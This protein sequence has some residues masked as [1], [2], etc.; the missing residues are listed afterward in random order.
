VFDVTFEQR[1]YFASWN[2]SQQFQNISALF[3][4]LFKNNFVLFISISEEHLLALPIKNNFQSKTHFHMKKNLLFFLLVACVTI[5][6]AQNVEKN[7]RGNSN[8]NYL[9]TSLEY[10]VG[11]TKYDNQSSNSVHNSIVANTDGTIAITYTF[12]P[13]STMPINPSHPNRGSGYNYYDGINW[14]A[15]NCTSRV[16]NVR[17]GFSNIVNTSSGA[18]LLIAHENVPVSTYSRIAVSRRAVKGTGTWSLSYPWGSTSFDTW[19]KAT[20]SGDNVYVVFQGSGAP[21]TTTSPPNIV[22]GQ[23]GPLYFSR[24][25]DGGITWDPKMII[26]LIDSSNY[27]GFE[28]DAYSIDARDSIVAISYGDSKIDVGLL[29]STDY[30][31]TWTKTI[32]QQHPIPFYTHDSITDLNH[33]GITDTVFT[34]GGDSHVLIDLNGICHV[35]FSAFRFFDND[36]SD[37]FTNPM[38]YTD[39]LEYWNENMASNA[40]VQIATAEDFNSNGRID[41]PVTGGIFSSSCTSFY[42]FGF[43]GKGLTQTPSAGIDAA[44]KIYLSYSTVDESADTALYG[45]LFRHVYMKTLAP[46]YNPGD[47]T[48]PYDIVPSLSSGGQGNHQEAVFAYTAKNVDNNYAHVLYQRDTIPGNSFSMFASCDNYQNAGKVNDIVVALVDVSTLSI[49]SHVPNNLYVSQN[50]PNPANRIT[51]ININLKKAADVK[52]I[53]SDVVGKMVYSE[54]KMKLQSGNHTLSVNTSQFETGIYYYTVF[55]GDQ[56]STKCMVVE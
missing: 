53:L 26:P 25:L 52:L 24:S 23:N 35:W 5:T 3:I 40:Y 19:V 49:A 20:S 48:Y 47:W 8:V 29:K 16:E 39:G 42:P 13:D 30:G 22:A 10:I 43:Y 44:G 41:Y 32:V 11:C 54:N 27:L 1:R 51:N 4:D 45:R 14:V 28:G 37:E 33:D 18:E 12:S 21:A 31:I 46:P 17:T 7:S 56:K 9:Q 2:L 50:Y 15:T 36:G 55:S 34:N 38:Y 6:T